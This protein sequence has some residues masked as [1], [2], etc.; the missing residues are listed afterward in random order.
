MP[1]PNL[2]LKDKLLSRKT[3]YEE[4]TWNNMLPIC[5]QLHLTLVDCEFTKEGGDYAMTVYIDKDGGVTVDDCQAVSDLLNPILDEQDYIDEAYI[6]YVSSPGLGR[7]LKR[8]HD[9]EFA[10]GKDI[11][12]RTYQAVD[13]KKEFT[14][15]LTGFDDKTVT[16]R[17]GEDQDMTIEKSKLSL[18]RLAFDF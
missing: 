15:T 18:I 6:L 4:K 2:C 9:F 14:G 17:I 10:M 8:Q 3:D 1:A 13:G 16:V 5:E 7:P 11:E 12:F